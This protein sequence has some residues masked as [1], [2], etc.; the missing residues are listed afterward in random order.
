MKPIRVILM[1]PMRVILMKP[2]R[3]I[4]MQ[5]YGSGVGVHTYRL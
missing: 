1:M 4:L 5:H 3:V 2:I